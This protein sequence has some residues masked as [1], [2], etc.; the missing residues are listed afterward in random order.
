VNI[1]DFT[2]RWATRSVRPAI[3]AGLMAATV[4]A[5][6]CGSEYAR[7]GQASSYLVIQELGGAVCQ[8]QEFFPVLRSDVQ[9]GGSVCEDNGQVVMT[10]AMRDVT[11]PN[12]PTANNAITVNRYRIA[13]RRSDGRN[14]PGV[15]IPFDIDG[16]VTFTIRP[17]DT[18][19]IGFSLVRAQ[20]KLE[21]PLMNLRGLGGSVVISTIAEV[22]FYGHD[23]AGRET[24]VSGNISVNF[25]DWAD[26]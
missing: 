1:K 22:T 2:M 7:Q 24:N 9:T 18:A 23:Q 17:G 20:A 26:K 4:G 3:A 6:A 19:S 15:D 8:D 13:Y 16:A 11:N 21:Q 12:T 10:A 14:T 25:A 5:A